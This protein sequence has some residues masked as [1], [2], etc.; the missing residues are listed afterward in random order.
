MFQKGTQRRNRQWLDV[1]NTCS[2]SLRLEV[3]IGSSEGKGQHLPWNLCWKK[4]T[5]WIRESEQKKSFK[6]E[7]NTS[8]LELLGW[9]SYASGVTIDQEKSGDRNNKIKTKRNKQKDY[10]FTGILRTTSI[11]ENRRKIGVEKNKKKRL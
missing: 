5:G 1:F 10:T 4:K 9:I 3:W 11:V 2:S 7:Q 6:D 8:I